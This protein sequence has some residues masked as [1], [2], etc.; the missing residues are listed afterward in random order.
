MK[1]YAKCNDYITCMALINPQLTEQCSILVEVLQGGEGPIP[2]VHVY[3]DKSRNPK[4]C[5]WVRLDKP[6]YSDHHGEIVKMPKKVKD[7]FIRIM[8]SEWKKHIVE[9]SDGTYRPAT[10]YEAAVDIWVDTY[11]K[12]SYDKFP[13]DE[14]GNLISIDYSNI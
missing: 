2:H 1:K 13:K 6:E 3:H 7:E 9:N 4:K 10:G 14:N 8:T 12:G 11:E 5:S